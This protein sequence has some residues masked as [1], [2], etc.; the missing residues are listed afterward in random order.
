MCDATVDACFC[1]IVDI[2]D[3]DV[4]GARISRFAQ[5]Q[6]MEDQS[7][8]MERRNKLKESHFGWSKSEIV[9]F[10][11]HKCWGN[12]SCKLD[13]PFLHCSLMYGWETPTSF[14]HRNLREGS[15]H[16]L[17]SS[18]RFTVARISRGVVPETSIRRCTRATPGKVDLTWIGWWGLL[19]RGLIAKLL[20]GMCTLSPWLSCR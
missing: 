14:D 7:S 15:W 10:Y 12:A 13:A 3:E 17:Q 19:Q 16:I 18:A 5:S 6:W 11:V 9:R 2:L 20:D 1:T 4:E 8:R